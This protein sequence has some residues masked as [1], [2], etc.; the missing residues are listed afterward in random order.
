MTITSDIYYFVNNKMSFTYMR[1]RP[2]PQNRQNL[3]QALI[4]SVSCHT[5]VCQYG[6]QYDTVRY[7][8]TIPYSLEAVV[9]LCR[10]NDWAF[11]VAQ[12]KYGRPGFDPWVEKIPW[13]RERLP[14]PVFWPGEFH[15]LCSPWGRKE[16][17]TTE[18]LSLLLFWQIVG[19]N[20]NF[21]AVHHYV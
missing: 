14:T 17:D 15:G 18:Q 9:C 16:L 7:C 1:I 20:L 21:F 12:L 13:R 3:R 10:F 4:L 5:I 11:L 6:C 8:H 19:E 2:S